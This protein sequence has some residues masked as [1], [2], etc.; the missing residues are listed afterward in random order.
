MTHEYVWSTTNVVATELEVLALLQADS[1][2]NTGS[3]Q[4]ATRRTLSRCIFTDFLLHGEF[5]NVDLGTAAKL[6]ASPYNSQIKLPEQ[7]PYLRIGNV[8][9]HVL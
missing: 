4:Q 5:Q 3:A 2:S 9:R 1:V 7:G 6:T 8:Q